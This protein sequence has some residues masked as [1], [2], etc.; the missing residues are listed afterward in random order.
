MTPFE[1]WSIVVGIASA[2]ATFLA[3]AVALFG[4][5]IRQLWSSPKL[6][7]RLFE[8]AITPTNGLEGL[9]LPVE[10][11]QPEA[12]ESLRPTSGS[13]S[14]KSSARHR[15][16]LGSKSPDNHTLNR[17]QVFLTDIKEERPQSK[18]GC[19]KKQNIEGSPQ[20][21][22]AQ[23]HFS[24]RFLWALKIVNPLGITTVRNNTYDEKWSRICFHTH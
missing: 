16:D 7:V 17:S 21:V 8:P 2:L 23:I 5:K 19:I 6:Q 11:F 20:V 3:V 10:D 14:P 1:K 13:C 18:N 15:M 4:E 12:L 9:V 22:P 24:R